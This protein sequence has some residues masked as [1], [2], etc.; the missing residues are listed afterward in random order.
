MCFY[1]GQKSVI[2][3]TN[4]AG[5]SF[6]GIKAITSIILVTPAADLRNSGLRFSLLEN[7]NPVWQGHATGL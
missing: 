6:Y 5:M 2:G 7:Q 3:K 1:I 4:T